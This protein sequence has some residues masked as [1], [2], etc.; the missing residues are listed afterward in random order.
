MSIT[1]M[2]LFTLAYIKQ[3]LI[4]NF[5]L[6]FIWWLFTAYLSFVYV[7][8]E[9]L[10]HIIITLF[11][12][13]WILWTTKALQHRVFNSRLFFKWVFKLIA[14]GILLYVWYSLDLALWMSIFLWVT[15][16]FIAVTD[17]SSI[18]EN[19]DEMGI[20]IPLWIRK[21]L[22][23]HKDKF[24]TDR[25]KALT[26]MDINDKYQDDLKMI[27]KYIHNIPNKDKREMFEI[28]IVYLRRIVNELID[29]KPNEIRTFELKIDLLFKNTW[30]ELER[31][32]KECGKDE[33]IIEAFWK[34]HIAR[35]VQLTKEL[36]D[37]LHDTKEKD[38]C[39]VKQNVIQT[40]IRIIY[41]NVADKY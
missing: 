27:D 21:V 32:I 33:E 20:P 19:L 23:V 13:D 38:L 31:K 9:Q 40:I 30:A 3:V 39:Q 34:S 28:K 10:F 29:M 17:I 36:E 16:S 7:W 35:F 15:F 4:D 24:F 1:A 26:G 11:I 2:S 12:I 5:L 25:I 22:S 18:L 41:K 6:K 14:Y 8:H 37:V